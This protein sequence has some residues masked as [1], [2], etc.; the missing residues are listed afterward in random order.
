V[1]VF[2][3]S[4]MVLSGNDAQAQTVAATVP[5]GGSCIFGN[6]PNNTL[7]AN[8]VP[9]LTSTNGGLSSISG[10]S[11]CSTTVGTMTG[12]FSLSF[13]G[14][15]TCAGGEAAGAGQ[16]VWSGALPDHP[17]VAAV[18]IGAGNS[19]SLLV[20]D[21]TGR[22]LAWGTLIWSSASAV[23]QCATGTGLAST[24]LTGTLVF[25]SV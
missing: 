12:S 24:Q 16:V 5:A 14:F 4:L 13:A 1:A 21:L 18:A 10:S 8:F 6:G 2:V 11:S 20:Y 3:G 7:T 15:W 23:A 17:S 19:I 25:V 22:L 9:A